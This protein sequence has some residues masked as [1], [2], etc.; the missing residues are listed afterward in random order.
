MYKNLVSTYEAIDN[1]GTL[2]D[3][4]DSIAI[5][6]Y[7][8]KS[9]VYSL[10]RKGGTVGMQTVYVNPFEYH[11]FQKFGDQAIS[12]VMEKSQ[13]Y[14]ESQGEQWPILHKDTGHATFGL[15]EVWG[16]IKGW[17]GWS[18][19][20]SAAS[21]AGKVFPG[22]AAVLGIMG[23]VSG[24]ATTARE[25]KRQAEASRRAQAAVRAGIQ[26]TASMGVSK[27]AKL[28]D[29]YSGYIKDTREEFTT[30]DKSLFDSLEKLK[31]MSKNL[32]IGFRD[33]IGNV[34]KQF[35]N[36]FNKT[37]K[38]FKLGYENEARDLRFNL[39]QDLSDLGFEL[40]NLQA[41]EKDAK[42]EDTFWEV[43]F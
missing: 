15:G 31:K 25:N 19:I 36:K 33:D 3:I 30:E 34:M 27:L 32:N 6:I 14:A 43:V 13:E 29:D 21:S 2:M 9:G 42:K 7:S 10:K 41:Q 38:E 18:K 40:R 8:N 23:T 5:N 16:A 20:G 12:Y 1:G 24:W 22:A 4:G 26:D 28:K 17:G 39:G 35:R 11:M 37:S